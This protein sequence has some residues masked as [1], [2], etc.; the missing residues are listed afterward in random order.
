MFLIQ[1]P[2]AD[3]VNPW[4]ASLADRLR[5]LDHGERHV[6]YFYPHP[7]TGTFRY[8]VLNMMEALSASGAAVGSSWFC[9]D[10][11]TH[12]D[13]ILVRADIVVICHAKYTAGFAQ[14]V[15]RARAWGKKILY[16]VDDLVFDHRYVHLVLNYLEH[17]TQEV[18]LDYWFA[19]FGRY[20]ALMR[21]CDGVIVTNDYLAERVRDFCGLPTTVVPN[22]MNRDQLEISA[23]ILECKRASGFARDGRI[24]LGYFSGSPTHRRDFAIM[25][26]AVL[27]LME[28]DPR[29]VLR[30]VGFLEP[31][32]RFTRFGD[33]VE[34]YPMQDILNL[35]R[36][37]GEVEIN[38]VPLQDNAFTNCKSELKVFEAAAVGTISL[39]SPTFTLSGAIRDGETG[40]IVPAHRWAQSLALAIEQLDAYPA[41]AMAAAEAA[42]RRY[43]PEAQGPIVFHALFG[44]FGDGQAT[45]AV[46]RTLPQRLG[47]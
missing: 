8:R 19:D 11:T 14:L 10:E 32:S 12:V 20:G 44:D 23:G 38:L 13:A 29:V 31:D 18:D 39:A 33:R 28:A 22:F 34:V 9:G 36:L 21:L 6:A 46:L 16:D 40:F 45:G 2:I 24:H 41:M 37:I 30:V 5:G 27:N 26:D 15:A 42:L 47:V 25:A 4:S 7:N 43:V 17:S 1:T 35:Q 3:Y